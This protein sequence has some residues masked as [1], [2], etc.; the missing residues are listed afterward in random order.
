[1]YRNSDLHNFHNLSEAQQEEFL[2]FAIYGFNPN[3]LVLPNYLT[4]SGS[5]IYDN[6][7]LEFVHFM[8]QPE[9]FWFTCKWLL[10]IDL[11]PFQVA[12]L[13]ELWNRK[14]PMLVA[15]RGAGKTFILAVYS[16]LRALFQQGSKVVI[17]GSGF[18]QA[19]FMF[20]YMTDIHYKSPILQSIA[21]EH[22]KR[23]VDECYYKIGDSRITGVP[24]GD[25]SKIRGLRATHLI[26]DE[27]SS[28]T[29]ETYE[30]VIKGF[31]VVSANP[32]ERA[33]KVAQMELYKQLNLPDKAKEIEDTL[34]IGNQTIISGT[35]YYS[36]N[37]FYQYWKRY[38]NI[39]ES[40]GDTRILQD[41]FQGKIEDGFDWRH[42]SIIRL[43]Y[44][45][46]PKGFMDES[47]ISS[48]KVIIHKSL[49]NMEYGAAFSE[50]SDGFFK[51]SLVETCVTKYPITTPGGLDVRFVASLTGSSAVEYVYGIDPA[52]E[53]DNLALT[54]LEVYPDHRRVVYCWTL[55]KHKLRERLKGSETK[56][57][58][59]N[60][61]AR[62]IRDLMKVFP[63]RHIG[64]DTQGGGRQLIEALHNPTDM[65][66]NE[67]PLWPYIVDNKN[68][69]KPD[70][71][72]WEKDGKPTDI[73]NGDHIIHEINFADSE[74]TSQSNHGL[75]S[76]LESKSILFPAY[77]MAILA[78][79][80][81]TDGLAN[82]EHDT[83]EDCVLEIEEMKDE[84]ATIEHS[85]TA[86]Q[87]RERW[88][89]PAIKKPGG[90]IGRQRKDRYTALIIA[91]MLARSVQHRLKGHD[92]ISIGGYVGQDKK[93]VKGQ[94][95]TGP[96][97]LTSQIP[98]NYRGLSFRR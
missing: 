72:W 90:K 40:H 16:I 64:I 63:T 56:I 21:G 29:Q 23:D 48:S 46:L 69:M 12:I 31:G 60:F 91:N 61:C 74:F 88:D 79:S 33:E 6:P 39:I 17:V 35:A 58:F 54:I 59:Y 30:V 28:I 18:R 85:Q 49:F 4:E 15:S 37:H 32:T 3:E 66:P 45:M 41:L 81:I 95:Y 27:F 11:H 57:G 53:N 70:P 86:V 62:K 55:N 47:Q 2:K 83:L 89:T 84:L 42:Y 13:Q 77:D 68:P 8:A 20:Q 82:R 50:D 10:N 92:H 94:L 71:F 78:E 26:A 24:I 22:P 36:F 65:L 98:P 76:D 87:S 25:G 67:K 1:M 43:P 73:E 80:A 34:G 52:S 19:K 14:F 96:E 7:H 38:K 9:N 44:N 93:K 75:R 5:G 51:R 97:S